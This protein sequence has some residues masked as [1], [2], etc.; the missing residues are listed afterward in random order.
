MLSS[1]SFTTENETWGFQS[2]VASN[3]VMCLSAS[4]FLIV[5]IIG[6]QNFTLCSGIIAAWLF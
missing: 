6:L 2:D 3:E 5:F 1:I 4:S